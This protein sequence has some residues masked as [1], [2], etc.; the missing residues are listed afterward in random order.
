[1]ARRKFQIGDRVRFLK[2]IGSFKKGQEGFVVEYL[3]FGRGDNI[4]Y[5]VRK[6]RT[7]YW[8]WLGS[9]ELELVR[10]AKK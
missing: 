5:R 10:G 7:S 2:T 3:K 6:F 1:M 8:L 4:P 9:R